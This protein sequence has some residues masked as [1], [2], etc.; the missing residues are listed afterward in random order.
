MGWPLDEVAEGG[1]AEGREGS[2]PWYERG[3]RGSSSTSSLRC[4]LLFLSTAA[5]EDMAL[6]LL[7]AWVGTRV[8][9]VLG[10]AG[11][12]SCGA[13]QGRES[14]GEGGVGTPW[15]LLQVGGIQ[16]GIITEGLARLERWERDCR[17]EPGDMG[18]GGTFFL[19]SFCLP[20]ASGTIFSC[21]DPPGM[22]TSLWGVA[23]SSPPPQPW[24]A[25]PSPSSS[26]VSEIYE[27]RASEKENSVPCDI[28]EHEFSDAS[29]PL[30]SGRMVDSIT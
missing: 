12:F 13:N 22:S 14:S 10:A 5:P 7:L 4:P 24:S 20:P 19:A 21:L 9:V 15:Y 11:R 16:V 1:E 29:V 18:G 27:S 23:F 6:M 30:P 3:V 28:I 25:S 17:G 26:S 8:W 2:R